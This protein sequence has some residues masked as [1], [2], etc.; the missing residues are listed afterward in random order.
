VKTWLLLLV[1][2]LV[3]CAAAFGWHAMAND[4]GY[5]LIKFGQTSVE[6][7][8]VFA[9]IAL[10]IV[11]GAVSLLLRLLRW[12]LAAWSRRSRRRGRE[13]ISSGLVALAEGRY[14]HA[15]REL[16][17]AS[18]LSG[19]QAPALLA[20]A[21]ASHARG[22]AVRTDA[23][24]TR[25]EEV[26][27]PAALAL[28]ARFLLETGNPQA[29]LAL[30]SGKISR[31]D[32]S[33]LEL[34]RNKVDKS[35]LAPAAWNMLAEAALAS[36]DVASART[37][38]DA[39]ASSQTLSPDAFAALENR[40]LVAALG[41]ASDA[42]RLHALWSGYSRAQRRMPDVLVA[43]ARRASKLGQTLAAVSELEDALR[44]EW[45]ERLVIAY[46]E[47]GAA[48]V[49]TRLRHAEAWLPLQPN[50]AGLRLTLG[51]LC[52][53]SDLW[54]KATD[55]LTRGL[56]I[57]PSPALWESFGDAASG[58]GD[59]SGAEC[60]YRNALRMGRG[61][62]T[63]DLPSTTSSPLDTRASVIEERSEHGVPR[64]MRPSA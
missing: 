21:R 61:E 46:G 19:L 4:P 45:S 8:L 17:R 29:A 59:D 36:G 63:L 50:S 53:Q 57:E 2:L 38:L 32:P 49:D 23:V 51:R 12:P 15:Q 31:P 34:N 25:A 26:A 43:Y 1:M 56:A 54:G 44:R 22:D 13:R 28:R 3:S 47:L 40:V 30:L 7:S 35:T 55:Y 16:E 33:A 27:A 39:L 52:I 14:A 24:L 10:L 60:G 62:A 58:Q 41:A 6:T 20:A 42:D 9:I 5:V 64:L 48:E 37:A 18:H 11:W